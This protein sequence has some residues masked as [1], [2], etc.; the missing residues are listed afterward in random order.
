MVACLFELDPFAALLAWLDA[1]IGGVLG[2]P[3]WLG[4]RWD[5]AGVLRGPGCFTAYTCLG[6]AVTG[7]D[8]VLVICVIECGGLEIL[9]AAGLRAIGAQSRVR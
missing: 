3:G 5:F 8:G 7:R 1:A 9:S 4:V 2:E 6:T